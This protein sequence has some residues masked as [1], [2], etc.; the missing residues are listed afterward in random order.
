MKRVRLRRAFIALAALLVIL[1]VTGFYLAYAPSLPPPADLTGVLQRESLMVGGM[2]R[3]ALY[4]VIGGGHVVS[5]PHYRAPRMLGR[6]T[7]EFNAPREIWD[8]F[9][10]LPPRSG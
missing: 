3:V 2:P 6:T 5:Q 8:F 1:A 4:S 7:P 9:S 10:R